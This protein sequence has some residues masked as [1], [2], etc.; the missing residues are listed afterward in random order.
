MH[1]ELKR[2]FTCGTSGCPR[3]RKTGDF[4]SAF[5]API[6]SARNTLWRTPKLIYGCSDWVWRT[7]H[8]REVV[9]QFTRAIAALLFSRIWVP[10]GNTG[11]ANVS[12][13]AP[14]P[15]PEDLARVLKETRG[16]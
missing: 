2:F 10:A 13:F 16:R 12:A 6:S 14:M 4:P 9:G 3:G 5:P 8:A 7:R 1:G 15:V 11:R